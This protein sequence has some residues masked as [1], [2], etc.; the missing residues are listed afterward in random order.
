[1]TNAG[2]DICICK[3]RGK[4]GAPGRVVPPL[5]GSEIFFALHSPR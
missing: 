5:R 4:D 1:M 2:E 3:T